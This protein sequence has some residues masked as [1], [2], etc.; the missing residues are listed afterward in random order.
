MG[1]H[2]SIPQ[3]GGAGVLDTGREF[4]PEPKDLEFLG[5][6]L[7]TNTGII[8]ASKQVNDLVKTYKFKTDKVKKIFCVTIIKSANVSSLSNLSKENVILLSDSQECASD[9]NPIYYCQTSEENVYNIYMGESLPQDALC[10]NHDHCAKLRIDET[11]NKWEITDCRRQHESS[12]GDSPLLNFFDDLPQELP[13]IQGDMTYRQHTSDK[14][15]GT[16]VSLTFKNFGVSDQMDE[17]I[18]SLDNSVIVFN[19]STGCT[20]NLQFD[21]SAGTRE[22]K[23]YH[24]MYYKQDTIENG[25]KVIIAETTSGNDVRMVLKIGESEENIR[26]QYTKSQNDEAEELMVYVCSNCQDAE[27]DKNEHAFTKYVFTQG[28]GRQPASRRTTTSRRHS[29]RHAPR[30]SPRRYQK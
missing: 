20:K 22:P 25:Q 17:N 5:L 1:N 13:V 2:G 12:L 24:G 6:K 9:K 19:T 18:A 15:C 4:N 11:R 7:Q 29:P 27:Y 26:I 8:M 16:Y 28:G 10:G 14:E 23:Y 21:D 3:R 30:H